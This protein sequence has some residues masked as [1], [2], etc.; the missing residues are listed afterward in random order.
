M[1]GQGKAVEG[2][3]KAVETT[4]A[5]SGR[6]RTG[7]ERSR[8][9]SGNDKERQW[10]VKEAVE[11]SRK[12]SGISRTGSG[13]VKDRQWKVK[14]RQWKGQGKAVEGQGKAV[15]T[16]RTSSG[17]VKDRQWKVNDRQAYRRYVHPG[18]VDVP[19]A[20]ADDERDADA[21]PPTRG[22]WATLLDYSPQCAMDPQNTHL[23]S[24]GAVFMNW[25]WLPWRSPW[26]EKKTTWVSSNSSHSRSASSSLGYS[27][28][29]LTKNA[30]THLCIPVEHTY[31]AKRRSVSLSL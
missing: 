28:T 20:A 15:E 27:G 10:Q 7:S 2:Q 23:S 26:S 8:T 3:G 19:P 11:R 21:A 30:D 18:A 5:G 1:E 31:S 4:K 9:G 16:T 29:V 12:G 17:T 13:K 22:D 25:P 14:D 24:Q 6:S